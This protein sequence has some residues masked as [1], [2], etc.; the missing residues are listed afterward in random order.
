MARSREFQPNLL[1]LDI[2]MQAISG[3][4]LASLLKANEHTCNIQIVFYSSDYEEN[5]R[6]IV[7]TCDVRGYI[8]KS[9]IVDLKNK[10]NHYIATPA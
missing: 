2:N 1:L 6:E 4:K 9:D 3:D 8:C 10:V 7:E 5:L